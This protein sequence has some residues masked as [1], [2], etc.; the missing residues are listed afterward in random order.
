MMI[1]L[2]KLLFNEPAYSTGFR[3]NPYSCDDYGGSVVP[4]HKTRRDLPGR[5]N[6]PWR[7]RH[8][9]FKRTEQ[10]REDRWD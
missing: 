2:K 5:D 9:S 3:L 10:R 6:R 1:L 4:R 8:A 7:A